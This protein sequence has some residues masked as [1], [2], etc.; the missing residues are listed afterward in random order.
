MKL[1]ITVLFG[2]AVCTM[3]PDQT[4]DFGD[5][6]APYPTTLTEE[7]AR[8]LAGGPVLGSVRDAESNGL[9]SVAAD[10]DDNAGIDDE[11]GVSFG[12][13]RV[14]AL[15]AEVTVSVTDAPAGAKLDAWVD[16]NADGCW[17]GPGERIAGGVTVSNGPNAMHFDVPG[18]ALDGTNFA[19]FRLSTAGDLGVAGAALDGEVEDHALWIRPSSPGT[20]AFRSHTI[21]MAADGADCVFAVDMEGD[22]DM[23]VLSASWLHDTIAWYEHI[24][25]VSTATAAEHGAISPSGSVYVADGGSVHFTVSPDV[26]YRVADVATNGVSV[27]AV[28]VFVWSSVTAA[29]SIHA[30]FAPDLAALG[31]P[32]WWLAGHGLTNG[33]L[34]FDQAEVSNPDRDPFAT[35]K[36]YLADTDPTDPAS[37][38]CIRAIS[39]NSAVML[40]FN[41]SSNRLYTMIAASNLLDDSWTNVPGAGPRKGVGGADSMQDTNAPSRRTFYRLSVELP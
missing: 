11:D 30:T 31:T 35:D 9:H 6:P 7:G 24:G 14:G 37:H 18:W 39:N 2:L 5:A 34:T 1:A 17:G 20:G 25:T 3:V 41:S 27:G 33:G 38:F 36:E 19:R 12:V 16:F 40:Y 32:H 26:Y 28:T 15:D 21:S 10:A 13:V 8:H 29:G 22:G 23:D 4:S